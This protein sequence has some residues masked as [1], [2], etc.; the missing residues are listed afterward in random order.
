MFNIRFLCLSMPQK[1]FMNRLMAGIAAM[2]LTCATSAAF[3]AD[4]KFPNKG[5]VTFPA[6]PLPL[7]IHYI[8]GSGQP[9][10][11]KLSDIKYADP[12]LTRSKELQKFAKLPCEVGQV[13]KLP[14]SPIAAATKGADALGIGRF[15]WVANGNYTSDGKS[16]NFTGTLTPVNGTYKFAKAEWGE[17]AWWAEV[18]TR[19]GATFPGKE[20]SANIA[21]TLKFAIHGT[22]TLNAAGEALV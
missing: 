18:A 5:V 9:V 6:G 20:F 22:C 3:S 17:R 15:S 19:L 12:D 8:S 10:D 14:P 16:W 7:L 11:V 4:Q 21:G 1:A 2:G 13:V